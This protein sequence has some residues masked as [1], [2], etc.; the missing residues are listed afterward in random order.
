MIADVLDVTT[1]RPLPE[2][3]LAGG[4]TG[5]DVTSALRQA[6]RDAP[7]IGRLPDLDAEDPG[8][9]VVRPRSLISLNDR[10]IKMSN[11][12]SALRNECS[13][14]AS[15]DLAGSDEY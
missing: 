10:A 13:N 2:I 12:S 4:E 8:P 3:Q 14:E 9:L 1:Y 15:S 6:L 11:S 5:V 7:R